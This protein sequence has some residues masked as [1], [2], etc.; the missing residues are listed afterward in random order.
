MYNFLKTINIYI[1]LLEIHELFVLMLYSYKEE[2]IS[3]MDQVIVVMYQTRENCFRCLKIS[4]RCIGMH[5]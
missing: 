3:V 1:F 5:R 4:R 2:E